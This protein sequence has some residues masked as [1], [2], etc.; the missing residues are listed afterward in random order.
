MERNKVLVVV[1]RQLDAEAQLLNHLEKVCACFTANALEAVSDSTKQPPF[2]LLESFLEEFKSDIT[3]QLKLRQ[4][5]LAMID[6][7]EPDSKRSS[8]RQFIQRSDEPWRSELENKRV[9]IINRIY[10]L[11]VQLAG[12]SAAV[13]Y[14]YDFYRRIINAL[15]GSS[16]Q[17]TEY[18]N[19]GKSMNQNSG[20]FCEKAC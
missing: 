6:D 16:V 3:K 10:E 7:V 18:S 5:T 2:Q 14:S 20:I 1:N 9:S 8:I 13:F 15:M 12:D 4:E 19:D 11:K 17:E